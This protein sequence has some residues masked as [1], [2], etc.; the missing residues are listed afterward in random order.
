VGSPRDPVTTDLDSCQSEK[1][2]IAG[3]IRQRANKSKTTI[4]RRPQTNTPVGFES[5]LS[6][7][8]DGEGCFTVS[9]SQRTKMQT[10]WELRPSFSVSQN[11]N[12][13]ATLYLMA[14]YFGCGTIR[15]D[16]SDKTLKYEVRSLNNLVNRIIPHFVEY[17]VLS[18]KRESFEAFRKI[19]LEMTAGMHL[20]AVHISSMLERAE[21]INDGKRKYRFGKI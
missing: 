11:Y 4:I 20:S 7:Y 1:S 5:Y 15:P 2:E 16:R 14:D 6:G 19:C 17:P 3:Y 8:V 12:R 18:E 21:M 9:V 13:A 10:G